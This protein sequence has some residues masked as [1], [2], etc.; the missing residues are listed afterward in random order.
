MRI[1]HTCNTDTMGE[2]VVAQNHLCNL[3]AISVMQF[4]NHL[5]KT[6]ISCFVSLGKNTTITSVLNMVD[7]E[8]SATHFVSIKGSILHYIF[9]VTHA[10][11]ALLPDLQSFPRFAGEI[12]SIARNHS[13]LHIKTL[14]AGDC[15]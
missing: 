3:A 1:V 13:V 12:L 10:H 9:A 14:W 15:V 5:T 11:S 4:E 7:V 6:I 8:D 2:F